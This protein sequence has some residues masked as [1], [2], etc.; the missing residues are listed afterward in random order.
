MRVGD[1]RQATILAGVAVL[2]VGFLVFQLLP[3]GSPRAAVPPVVPA[4]PAPT[5]APTSASPTGPT[6]SLASMPGSS[7]SGEVAAPRR[8]LRDPFAEVPEATPSEPQ[9]SPPSVPPPVSAPPVIEPAPPV[10]GGILPPA[11]LSEPPP[12]PKTSVPVEPK[13]L[14]PTPPKVSVVPK[15]RLVLRL[16][17][18]VVDSEGQSNVAMVRIGERETTLRAGDL[19]GEHLR[20]AAVTLEG[21]TFRDRPG[22]PLAPGDEIL[23]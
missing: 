19:V 13:R 14:K 9:G 21:L 16:V 5:S 12:S 11:G 18:V 7:A 23:L 8:L 1:K 10:I 4:A 17:G 22:A 3:K 15:P 2:A 20:V 6:V